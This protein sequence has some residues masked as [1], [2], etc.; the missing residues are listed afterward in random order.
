MLLEKGREVLHIAREL[1]NRA[2]KLQQ[3]WENSLRLA[4]D[5]TFP[6]ALLSPPIAAFYQQQPLTRLHFT[7]NPSLLDWRPLTDGQADLMLGAL[8]EPPPL[9][10]YDYLPSASWSCCWSL[11]HSIRWRDTA[12]R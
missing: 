2:F 5:S 11:P 9:S 12:H 1:E 4:V 10:G 3:G 6:V 8:G 7:L